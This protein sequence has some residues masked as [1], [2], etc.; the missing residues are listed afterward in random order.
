[1]A[2]S[3][4]VVRDF[5]YLDIDKLYSLY[6][7][8][9]EGVVGQIVQ[10]FAEGDSTKNTQK[11]LPLS[12]KSL[13]SRVA[14]ASVR[15]E[16]KIL[17]DHMYDRLEQRIAPSLVSG[18][19]ISA[20]NI[21]EKFGRSF[22]VKATGSAE[23]EDYGRMEAFLEKFNDVAEAIAYAA[24]TKLDLGAIKELEANIAEVANR[25]KR[26]IAQE[27]LKKLSPDR[28]AK[29]FA[30]N[31]GLLQ[32]QKMLDNL[33]LLI[34]T[35][36]GKAFEVTIVPPAS[37]GKLAFRGVLDKKWLRVDPDQLNALYG[38]FA[39]AEWT[40][41]GHV[42]HLPGEAMPIS[43]TAPNTETATE[44]S[45]EGKAPSMRDPYRNMFR[46]SRVLERMF[47]ESDQRTEIVV[48]PIAIYRAMQVSMSDD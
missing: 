13:D 3:S 12:G 19:D 27:R 5:I 23:I 45:A 15:T 39:E 42:T 6:S 25:N 43:E 18:K 29:E 47:M 16:N 28:L 33:I 7:Q 37:V 20:E 21:K 2:D 35:F 40:I 1:M 46:S 24:V 26:R 10:S 8:L 30:A 34:S 22:L 14:A 31:Q 11:G 9:F 48:S 17:Y 44:R 32:D 38:G 41:V 4:A 36:H